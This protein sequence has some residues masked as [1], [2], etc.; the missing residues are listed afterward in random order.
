MEFEE[1]KNVDKGEE[2]AVIFR[3]NDHA[4]DWMIGA[5][6]GKGRKEGKRVHQITGPQGRRYTGH[7]VVPYADLPENMRDAFTADPISLDNDHPLV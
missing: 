3:I 4:C 6:T 5:Y 1:N 2:V 7:K